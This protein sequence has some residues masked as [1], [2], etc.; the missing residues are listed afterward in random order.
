MPVGITTHVLDTARG[1]PAT[2][3]PVAL[4]IFSGGEWKKVGGALTDV[5]GRAKQLL[6]PDQALKLGTYRLSFDLAA[7][8][9]AQGVEAFFPSATIIFLVRDADQHYHVPLLLSPYSYSTYRGS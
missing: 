9:A 2:G 3:V 7:W 5:D 4:E 6:P 8:F 1:R